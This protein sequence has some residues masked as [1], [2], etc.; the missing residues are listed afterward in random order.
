MTAISGLAASIRG[1]TESST[2]DLAG[3]NV[4]TITNNI[5][6]AFREPLQISEMIRITFVT[7][8]GKLGRQKYDAD[9]AKA[10]TSS[11]R[12]L[13]FEEDRGASCVVECAG[14]FNCSTILER[15]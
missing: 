10:V 15:T 9:A 2:F 13:G 14:S 6:A 7:G 11:L 1:S 4:S 3:Q 12:E 5:Q 8:A